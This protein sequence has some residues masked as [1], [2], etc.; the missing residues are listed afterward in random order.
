MKKRLLSNNGYVIEDDLNWFDIRKI[1]LSRDNNKCV[2]CGEKEKKLCI[3]HIDESGDKY[4]Y[5]K[6]NNELNNLETLCLSCHS[7][8]HNQLSRDRG[9]M[10][11]NP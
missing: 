9:R 1:I 5:K 11:L 4:Y 10:Y 8:L 7:R 6:P 2:K 3:H